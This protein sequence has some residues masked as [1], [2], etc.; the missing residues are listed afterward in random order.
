MDSADWESIAIMSAN[1][2][3]ILSRNLNAAPVNKPAVGPT[4][5]VAAVHAQTDPQ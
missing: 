3:A 2:T 5:R 4:I 1:T